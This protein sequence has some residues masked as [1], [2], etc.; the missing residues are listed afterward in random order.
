[1]NITIAVIAL[2][3]V[4]AGAHTKGGASPSNAGLRQLRCDAAVSALPLGAL[5][6]TYYSSAPTRPFSI[7]L[8][9]NTLKSGWQGQA[10]RA[11]TLSSFEMSRGESALTCENVRKVAAAHGALASETGANAQ[12]RS[13]GIGKRTAYVHRMSLPALDELGTEAIAEV[14]SSSNQLGGGV[15]LV[16]LHKAGGRWNVVGRKAIVLS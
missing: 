12:L 8:S 15:Y 1:M 4:F 2:F 9:P 7:D 16:L 10:P 13:I 6:D 3:G 11:S 14:V 5:G